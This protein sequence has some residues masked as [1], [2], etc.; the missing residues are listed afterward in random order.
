MQRSN[1]NL[2]ETDT[3]KPLAFKTSQNERPS[4]HVGPQIVQGATSVV[5][6]GAYIPGTNSVNLPEPA[7]AHPLPGM[8]AT[9]VIQPTAVPSS[10]PGVTEPVRAQETSNGITQ[11]IDSEQ[12]NKAVVN[13][14][15]KEQGAQFRP[16]LGPMM[17]GKKSSTDVVGKF[18]KAALTHTAFKPRA[19]GAGE[20]LLVTRT[21]SGD[22]PD[23]ITGV[24]PAPSLVRGISQEATQ[25]LS[26]NKAPSQIPQP[27][28]EPIPEYASPQ[29][30][31]EASQVPIPAPLAKSENRGK[32][33]PPATEAFPDPASQSQT[34][35]ASEAIS[36]PP[37]PESPIK[38][39][40]K[41]RSS[42]FLKGLH[43]MGVD[44]SMLDGLDLI[45]ENVLEDL[46]WEASQHS[47]SSAETLG[48]GLRREIGKLEAGSWLNNSDQRYERVEYVEQMLEKAIMECDELEGLLT[49]YG[50]ELGVSLCSTLMYSP[51][52]RFTDS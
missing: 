10:S 39:S 31:Q 15:P 26:I 7:L 38:I 12:Q 28:I 34:P 1:S 27:I 8:K 30:Q 13:Q 52:N 11:N 6:Q 17:G 19:G 20:R 16:G 2:P 40:V 3:V 50:V 21:E 37:A 51:I 47:K 29:P 32:P 14:T 48:V 22:E 45:F 43:S 33:P 18:R 36:P 24:V 23:G 4:P 42:K 35:Q 44:P 5:H 9:P 25:P 41:P 46:G 49:L